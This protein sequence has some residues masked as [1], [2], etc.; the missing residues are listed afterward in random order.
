MLR[1]TAAVFLGFALW[2][3]LWLGSN[4]ALNAAW[5]A[6]FSTDGV[7]RSPLALGLIL[8][9][10]ALFSI[11]AGYITQRGARVDS[12]RPGWLLGGLLL[13]VGIVV[14]IQYWALMPLWYHLSFLALLV[15]AA[16][17]GSRVHQ[18]QDRARWAAAR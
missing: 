15:P 12:L 13:A 4:A 17:T 9:L 11:A 7:A 8:L 18:A 16:L 5:P 3:V 2:T 6:A 1:T 10:S 14:Q